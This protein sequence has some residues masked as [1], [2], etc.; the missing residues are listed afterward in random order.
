[1]NCRN[2]FNTFR[3]LIHELLS[4]DPDIDPEET[5]LV[6]LGSKSAICMSKNGKD[7]KHTIHISMSVHLVRNGE[8][9]SLNP[10]KVDIKQNFIINISSFKFMRIFL[11]RIFLFC[12][13]NCHVYDIFYPR[14]TIPLRFITWVL[15]FGYFCY[16]LWFIV[17]YLY[18]LE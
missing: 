1:M 14:K 5:P 17:I 2:V 18:F 4:K 13:F 6:V 16:E 10:I 7:T 12:I 9:C 8:R 15:F 3:M 11:F